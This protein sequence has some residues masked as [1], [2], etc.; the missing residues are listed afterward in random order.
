MNIQQKH[1]HLLANDL[2][3]ILYGR[4]H[5]PSSP[6]L[7]RLVGTIP[8]SCAAGV[9][10]DFDVE[11]ITGHGVFDS[12]THADVE[13]IVRRALKMMV[14]N[15][16]ELRLAIEHLETALRREGTGYGRRRSPRLRA[17]RSVTSRAGS[18]RIGA[19]D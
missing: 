19:D 5:T 3:T 10:R 7:R 6:A 4:T 17:N 15:G 12:A 2:E 9:H 13:R 11:E 8:R 14:L 1:H 16:G 18:G